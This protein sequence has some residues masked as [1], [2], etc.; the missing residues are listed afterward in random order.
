MSTTMVAPHS[1]R[2]IADDK[3]F[4]ANK[5]AQEAAKKVG[6]EQVINSTLG[7]LMED[8]GSLSVMQSVMKTF[9]DLPDAEIAAYA[10]IAGLPDFQ[11]AAEKAVFD[12]YRPAGHVRAVA[13]PGGSGG[14]RHAVWNYME[15]G[16]TMLTADW[17]WA[18]YKTITEEHGR[19]L[20]TFQLFD[21]NKAFNL[22][23][24]KEKVEELLGKQERLLIMMNTP[25][26]NPTGYSL[27]E[28]EWKEV[29]DYLK[30]KQA[31]D[32]K[33]IILY[34]DIAYIDFAGD[35]KT[36]RGFMKQFENLPESILVLVGYSMS[37]AFT[38]YG[39]RCGALLCLSSSEEI[40]DEFMAAGTFSSR[41]CWSNGTRGAQKLLAKV[42]SDESLLKKVNE[43][44]D[45]FK[46][47]LETRAHAFVEEAEMVGLEIFPYRAGFFITIP[48]ENPDK[49]ADELAKN[50]LFL[51]PLG[52]GLRFAPCAVSEAKCRKSVRF[53]KE[54]MDKVNG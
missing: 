13:T 46:K 8:D 12:E 1:K 44:R 48:C 23:S 9:K 28:E 50:H 29:L 39:L 3:V 37:K 15:A 53:I 20:D 4:A 47:L 24:F 2:P 17:Y 32:Q 22:P 36:S 14:I 35:M 7:A 40:A 19:K 6:A 10:P 41:A 45:S 31:K 18:P 33:K 26:H 27:T 43:E 38:F 16:D 42:Y 5:K 54:A 11:Q 51:L 30:E 25:A 34:L 52:R 21:E 49:V